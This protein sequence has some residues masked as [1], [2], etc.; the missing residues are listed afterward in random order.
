MSLNHSGSNNS[1]D[2]NELQ[3]LLQ[4]QSH[5]RTTGPTRRSTKGGWTGE[6]EDD[7]IIELVG[8]EGKKKW[9]EI[10]S[11]LPGRIGKQCRERW[12][13]HLN[14][15]INKAAWTKVEE[16]VLVKAQSVH[17]NRWAEIA[18]LLPGRTEN[19]IKNHWNCSLKKKMSLYLGGCPTI[20]LPAY[21]AP[22][23]SSCTTKETSG[24]SDVVKRS[25][26]T[27]FSPDQKEYLE[28]SEQDTS[29][30]DLVLGCSGTMLSHQQE[31]KIQNT[32]TRTKVADEPETLLFGYVISRK[33]DIVRTPTSERHQVGFISVST[34]GQSDQMIAK[35]PN[36]AT[37]TDWVNDTFK[38]GHLKLSPDSPSGMAACKKR[39]MNPSSCSEVAASPKKLLE[40][41]RQ[42]SDDSISLALGVA[43]SVS[44]TL[45]LGNSAFSSKSAEEVNKRY[46]DSSTPSKLDNGDYIGLCYEPL[47]LK[48]LNCLFENG[49]FPS[50]DSFI[51]LPSS[52]PDSIDTLPSSNEKASSVNW[53]SPESILRSVARNYGNMPSIIR[54]R[55][56]QTSRHARNLKQ[57][58]ALC[59]PERTNS[60]KKSQTED[61]R[62]S[63]EDDISSAISRNAKQLV[64]LAPGSG[65]SET[66]AAKHSVEKRLEYAFEMEW[67][68][69][70]S[71]SVT[72]CENQRMWA[73]EKAICIPSLLLTNHFV[74]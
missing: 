64:L 60:D 45:S 35:H 15:D 30:L 11:H 59:T 61:H 68:S 17:G 41:P 10:A 47:H 66:S 48:D 28:G 74:N 58:D 57:S 12:H 5:K 16:F 65:K 33:N 20:H 67:N 73:D 19:S 32:E 43:D 40:Y 14:P 52:P 2:T 55:G 1:S 34:P 23:F 44:T 36:A 4:D 46:K 56:I 70:D 27:T 22:N 38:S 49:T 54:R 13:N 63:P 25:Q 29:Y 26:G 8:K 31:S 18:K 62:P 42:I 6:E 7:L 51:R 3:N 50:T 69:A 37:A 39:K 71:K 9:S 72:S 53:S 24:E 21:P